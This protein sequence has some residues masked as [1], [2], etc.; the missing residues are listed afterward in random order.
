[1]QIDPEEDRILSP[2]RARKYL[3]DFF[4]IAHISIYWGSIE[5]FVKGL[6][7]QW[8]EGSPNDPLQIARGGPS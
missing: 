2:T 3:E 5:D 8:S 1:V 6:H 7:T 4:E